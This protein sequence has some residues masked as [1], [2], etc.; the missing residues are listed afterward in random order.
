MGGKGGKAERGQKANEK[1][2]LAVRKLKKQTS[3]RKKLTISSEPG[4]HVVFDSS[5]DSSPSSRDP[6]AAAAAPVQ[7]LFSSGGESDEEGVEF[8]PRPE[9]EGRSGQRLLALQ[10]KTGGDKRFR[11]SGKFLEEDPEPSARPCGEE[12]EGGES[13]DEISRQ[14]QQEK[15]SALAILDSMVGPSK[16]GMRGAD[17]DCMKDVFPSRYDPNDP[18]SRQLEQKPPSEEA[19][20][21][22]ED[23]AMSEEEEEEEE[24]GQSTGPVVSSEHYFK[25]EQDLQASF[26]GNERPF[27]LLAELRGASAEE[28]EERGTVHSTVAT[29][30]KP[31]WLDKL[32]RAAP[33]ST[34]CDNTAEE[35]SN[36]TD[37]ETT[38]EGTS[39]PTVLLFFFHST[40]A[41]LSNRLDESTFH[42]RKSLAELEQGWPERRAALKKSFR[43]RHREAVKLNRRKRK[44][45][46][47]Q[48]NT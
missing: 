29:S 18:A 3:R 31:R 19:E 36:N 20:R 43:Q 39:R 45:Y 14:L 13:R 12:E 47:L 48:D 23:S 6:V 21:S 30:L 8:A 4:K 27:S 35:H 28:E 34:L 37:G 25:V 24:G 42:R 26:A 16:P 7:S 33:Q 22:D 38:N 9:F 5:D 2:L 46:T 41:E 15:A 32:S 44:H 1:R 17:T 40:S 10:Q 11:L